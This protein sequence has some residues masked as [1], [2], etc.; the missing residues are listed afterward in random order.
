[1]IINF[2]MSHLFGYDP[3]KYGEIKAEEFTHFFRRAY[4]FTLKHPR[5]HLPSVLEGNNFRFKI[6]LFVENLKLKLIGKLRSNID[7][8]N[9]S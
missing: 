4:V 2:T 9:K 1:M 6:K 7:I 8:K 5:H 3:V